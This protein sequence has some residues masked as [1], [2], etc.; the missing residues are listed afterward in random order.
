MSEISR[1]SWCRCCKLYENSRLMFLPAFNCSRCH[2]T[3][4]NAKIDN[5]QQPNGGVINTWTVWKTINKRYNRTSLKIK[6]KKKKY[7]L[8][9][10]TANFSICPTESTVLFRLFCGDNNTLNTVTL[11]LRKS[12]TLCIYVSIIDNIGCNTPH[13][14]RRPK[15]LWYIPCVP[16]EEV[17]QANIKNITTPYWK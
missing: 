15:Y 3:S 7:L 13:S 10:V 5:R 1:N 11:I 16:D 4:I 6:K 12:F 8:S 2:K 17:T 14:I 9:V